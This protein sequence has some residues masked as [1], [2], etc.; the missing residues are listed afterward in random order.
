MI[1]L[2]I[3]L[4]I[5]FAATFIGLNLGQ[6]PGYVLIKTQYWSAETTIWVAALILVCVFLL[7]HFIYLIFKVIFCIPMTLKNWWR[8]YQRL[9]AH[10]NT[11]L[12]LI[13]FSEGYWEAARKHFIAAATHADLP[14][15]NYL[16]A[17]HSAQKLGQTFL[18]DDFLRQAQQ[19]EPKA[20]IA[21]KLTQAQLQIAAAQWE[22]ALATLQHLHELAPKHPYVINLL[23]KV[24][25][26]VKDWQQLI[27]LLPSI[28]RSCF[29]S[30]EKIAATEEC[31]YLE[32]LREM[33]A[34]YNH[35]LS[36]RTILENIQ[37]FFNALP[38]TLQ[39]KSQ[40]VLIY[41]Q[42]LVMQ[43]EWQL[44]NA[45]IKKSLHAENA[46]SIGINPALIDLYATIPMEEDKLQFSI[47][48]LKLYPHSAAIQALLGKLYLQARLF[49]QAKI[50]LEAS[51]TIDPKPQ[52]YLYL[53]EAL[54]IL[55]L[56]HEAYEKLKQGLKLVR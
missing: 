31:I 47:Q 25:E 2:F 24:Y 18:R 13:E 42:F 46:S 1:R 27:T 44:A 40:F 21:V 4:F 20:N 5:L 19:V 41:C 50:H 9:K 55:E 35:V 22:Q 28:K 48:L 36:S 29:L 7:L 43:Q 11:Y 23:A 30:K 38:K 34:Q 8:K 39:N 56:H 54:E 33:C 37:N 15:F 32:A 14:L 17:A 6:D 16:A 26:T 12:G 3:I 45:L 52:N 53:A 10:D 51:I 49:G